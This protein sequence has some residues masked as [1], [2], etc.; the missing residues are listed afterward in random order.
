MG[1][2]ISPSAKRTITAR[3]HTSENGCRTYPTYAAS[4]SMKNNPLRT[5][6]RSVTQAT[7]STCNGWIANNAAVNALGHKPA[8]HTLKNQ[9]E[10]NGRCGV[11][12]HIG[13]MVS[14]RVQAK[15]LTVQHEGNPSQRDPVLGMQAGKRPEKPCALNPCKT[16]GLS[17]T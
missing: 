11:Q 14:P 1:L 2:A 9:K 12:Q 6:F 7:D 8:R 3:Y 10:Q 17:K 5:S 13:Q 15:E 4:V 16:S